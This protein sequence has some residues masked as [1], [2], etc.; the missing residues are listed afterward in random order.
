LQKADLKDLKAILADLGSNIVSRV[1]PDIVNPKDLL[2]E[3]NNTD[4]RKQW[5]AYKNEQAKIVE[6]KLQLEEVTSESNKKTVVF[7]DD[8]DR[9][10]P[11]FSIRIIEVI[12]HLFDLDNFIFILFI[13][14]EQLN[15]TISAIYGSEF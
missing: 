2:Q 13:D 4:R 3:V 5:E 9:C 15:S 6:I 11:L 7:I 10:K 14:K 8:L 12:K 1:T